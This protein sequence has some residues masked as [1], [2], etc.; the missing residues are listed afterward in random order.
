MRIIKELPS[1]SNVAAGA[2]ATLECPVGLTYDRIILEYSGVTLAQMLNISV[3]VN[4]KPVQ[5]FKTGTRLGALNDYY[6]RPETAGFLSLWFN[7]QEMVDLAHR[8]VTGLGTSDVQTLQIRV[9][10]DAAAV[11]P[12]VTAHAILSDPTPLGLLNKV[13]EFQYAA[14]VIGQYEIDNIPRGPR[15]QAVHF[16][17]DGITD[18]EVELDSRKVTDASKAL[19]QAIQSEHG[20]TPSASATVVDYCLEGDIY[21]ALATAQVRDLRFRPTIDAA[22]SAPITV[23]YLDQ[24]AGI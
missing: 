24:F 4:G 13:K 9:D 7:R 11:S 2:T 14:S 10:V 15:I 18:I 22:E 3:E 8:R 23:E 17:N 16:W 20:R 19:L 21:Q 5:A 6:G 12:A 1:L